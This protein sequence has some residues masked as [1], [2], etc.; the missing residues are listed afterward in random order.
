MDLKLT[1]EQFKDSVSKGIFDSMDQFKKEEFVKSSIDSLL[2]RS[3][4]MIRKLSNKISV[5]NF[6]GAQGKKIKDLHL[7]DNTLVFIFSD[8]TGI[9]FRDDGGETR[10]E[11]RYMSTDDDL[12]YYS[13]ANFIG[14]NLRKAPKIKGEIIHEVQ[15][16]AIFTSKGEF[17]MVNH[18]IHEGYYGGFAITVSKEEY[19]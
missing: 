15:F 6:K 8:N 13:G 9:T 17:V 12:S 4:N 10:C 5:D 16:L 1:D 7:K 18:A 3:D 11:T 2:K 19:K 14:A